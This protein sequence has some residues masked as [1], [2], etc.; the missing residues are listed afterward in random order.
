MTESSNF[1]S[2][3]VHNFECF[4]LCDLKFAAFETKTTQHNAMKKNGVKF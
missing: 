1:T 2:F 4:E 3:N